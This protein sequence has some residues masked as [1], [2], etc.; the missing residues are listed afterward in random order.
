MQNLH[1]FEKISSNFPKEGF[2]SP[3]PPSSPPIK[4]GGGGGGGKCIFL[5]LPDIYCR[6]YSFLS[7]GLALA[8][9]ASLDWFVGWLVSCLVGL[10]SN[11]NCCSNEIVDGA[12]CYVES[13]YCR[14]RL[15]RNFQN[16][17]ETSRTF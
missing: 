4:G 3:H 1:L 12:G 2:W 5:I 9:R 16:I 6:I 14:T 8:T 11:K 17:L 10:S 13:I 15:C 7:S